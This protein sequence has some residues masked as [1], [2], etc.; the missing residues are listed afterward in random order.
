MKLD[1]KKDPNAQ[2]MIFASIRRK[3]IAMYKDNEIKKIIYIELR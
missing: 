3:L 1:T 2:D